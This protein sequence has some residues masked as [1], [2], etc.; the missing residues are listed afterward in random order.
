MFEPRV[1]QCEEVIE[2]LKTRVLSVQKRRELRTQ[3]LNMRS[4]LDF[5]FRA[6]MPYDQIVKE[7]KE[8]RSQ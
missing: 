6:K 4:Y 5:L 8:Y 2:F 3:E 7:M 1:E